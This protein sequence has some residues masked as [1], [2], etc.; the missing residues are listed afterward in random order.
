M[1]WEEHGS[2]TWSLNFGYLWLFWGEMLQLLQIWLIACRSVASSVQIR[3]L[4]TNWSGRCQFVLWVQAFKHSVVADASILA[5]CIVRLRPYCWLAVYVSGWFHVGVFTFLQEKERK[6]IWN[7][8]TIRAHVLWAK[9]ENWFSSCLLSWLEINSTAC[10]CR[11]S[12]GHFVVHF[13]ELL[14]VWCFST[15]VPDLGHVYIRPDAKAGSSLSHPDL[16]IPGSHIFS[17][18]FYQMV[19]SSIVSRSHG[20]YGKLLEM[21]SRGWYLTRCAWGCLWG[22]R[23]GVYSFSMLSVTEPSSL[24]SLSWCNH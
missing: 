3:G 19:L 12:N 1:L 24:L 20:V 2:E 4:V 13:T 14:S 17:A 11:A 9:E 23:M 21:Q 10:Q 5:P 8:D 15:E 7:V 16:L 6:T 22:V 18:V